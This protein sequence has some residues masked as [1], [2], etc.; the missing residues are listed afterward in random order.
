[1]GRYQYQMDGQVTL[2]GHLN[3]LTRYQ[4]QLILSSFWY[5]FVC[6]CFA[7]LKEGCIYLRKMAGNKA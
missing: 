2:C 1:L 6:Q 5:Q 7:G 3:H 4:G